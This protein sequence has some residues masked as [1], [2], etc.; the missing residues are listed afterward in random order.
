MD[1]I[2]LTMRMMPTEYGEWRDAI[3]Q[4]WANHLHPQNIQPV[5][6]PNDPTKSPEYLKDV[7][8]LILSGGDDIVL[9]T[10]DDESDNPNAIRDKSEIAIFEAAMERGIPVLGI[11]RG[12]QFINWYFGG[13]LEK[14]PD[15]SGHVAKY[16]DITVT[17]AE[18]QNLIPE[19]TMNV[20]SFHQLDIAE[21]GEN[22]K[23]FAEDPNG[24]KEGIYH[25]EKDVTAILW[26]PERKFEDEKATEFHSNLIRRFID[27]RG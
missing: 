3:A 12:L 24:V 16:H 1:K 25:T 6:V 5:L 19:G 26:H 13:T 7:K 22:L 9:K 8:A 18:G 23:I 21:L 2:A 14:M 11:C 17:D 10:P 27:S 20:N 4:D 15:A